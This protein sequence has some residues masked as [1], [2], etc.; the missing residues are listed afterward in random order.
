MFVH[1]SLVP[2]IAAAHELKTKADQHSVS[3]AA[4]AGISPDALVLR[5]DR[6][7]NQSI[8]DKISP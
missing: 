2:Y 4:P 1:V 5:S 3:D 7:L 8:K 6:P